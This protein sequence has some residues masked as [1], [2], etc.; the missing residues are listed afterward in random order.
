M[1]AGFPRCRVWSCLSECLV[2]RVV[3][4]SACRV[5]GSRGLR[6]WVLGVVGYRT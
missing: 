6:F 4:F 3:R 1:V 5:M 2:C